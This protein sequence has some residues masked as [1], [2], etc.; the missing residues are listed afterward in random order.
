MIDITT[1]LQKSLGVA[2]PNHV[3]MRANITK[4]EIKYI[5]NKTESASINIITA[6]YIKIFFM[7]VQNM[8][9]GIPLFEIISACQEYNNECSDFT[10]YAVEAVKVA[11]SN[12]PQQLFLKFLLMVYLWKQ[13]MS[14]VL[15]FNSWTG[16]NPIQAQ[17][18]IIKT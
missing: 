17:W 16:K 12:I 8:P 14:C 4:Y 9:P 15:F 5:L 18:I 7:A 10:K 2:F 3:L 6:S 13:L 1:A 11:I